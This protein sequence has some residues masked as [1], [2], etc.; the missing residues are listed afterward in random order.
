M[1]ED[2]RMNEEQ[3][4]ITKLSIELEKAILNGNADEINKQ[5]E[6]ICLDL[7]TSKLEYCKF[8]SNL[9]KNIIENI[10]KINKC[11]E[12]FD[13]LIEEMEKKG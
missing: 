6:L 12:P 4:H 8:A 10:E 13:K 9:Y 1:G 2:R 3:V 5:I 11:K 7:G